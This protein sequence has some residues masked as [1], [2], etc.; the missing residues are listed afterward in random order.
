MTSLLKLL[1]IGFM[2]IIHQN[3]LIAQETATKS[4]DILYLKN[5]NIIKG[6]ILM[7]KTG[8]AVK[9]KDLS[10][11]NYFFLMADVSNIVR[12]TTITYHPE[13]VKIAQPQKPK[14]EFDP[15]VDIPNKYKLL[16]IGGGIYKINDLSGKS[17][18]QGI[19]NYTYILNRMKSFELGL[20]IGL[21]YFSESAISVPFFVDFRIPAYN[22]SGNFTTFAAWDLGY[23]GGITN[24]GF[25]WLGLMS[26]PSLGIG[27][28]T[29]EDNWIRF[30]LAGEVQHCPD[31]EK[32][33][34]LNL[35]VQ[36]TY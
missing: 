12:D 33:Y 24:N 32:I 5:G 15:M 22:H 11:N 19:I 34:S 2:L 16:D 30:G 8:E 26:R 31:D 9:I 3:L 23:T 13:K 20:G 17:A 4:V 36:F 14:I 21:R 6:E 7:E 35:F 10:G 25:T 27:F 29:P 1:T 18:F 28:K